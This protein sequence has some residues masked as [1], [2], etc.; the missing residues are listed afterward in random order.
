MLVHPDIYWE[1]SGSNLAFANNSKTWNT[2]S[3][4]EPSSE[5]QLFKFIL[6]VDKGVLYNVEEI[7]KK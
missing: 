2:L 3:E 5:W 4:S 1:Y 7:K 6:S